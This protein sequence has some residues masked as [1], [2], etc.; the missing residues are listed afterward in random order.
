M[1]GEG[2]NIELV[3]NSGREK[4][5]WANKRERDGRTEGKRDEWTE[6]KR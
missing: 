2:K 5:R 4:E 1:G 3:N 6:G